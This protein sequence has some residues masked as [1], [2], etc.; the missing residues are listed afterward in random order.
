MFLHGKTPV[1]KHPWP[2]PMWPLEKFINAKE[3]ILQ[4]SFSQSIIENDPPC[5]LNRDH[6][7]ISVKPQINVVIKIEENMSHQITLCR[8]HIMTVGLHKYKCILIHTK[9][10]HFNL[11][12]H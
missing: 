10:T 8:E 1:G 4:E 6:G 5:S 9:E 11:M 2:Q 3:N 7:P 12:T